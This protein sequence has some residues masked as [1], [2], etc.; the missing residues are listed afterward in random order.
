[1]PLAFVFQPTAN[2]GLSA[3]EAPFSWPT[4]GRHPHLDHITTGGQEIFGLIESARIVRQTRDGRMQE[5]EIKL[6]DWVFNAIRAH[7]VLTISR[8]YFRLRRPLERRLYELARK[9]CGN[10]KE[11]VIG[12]DL[13]QKK[14]GSSS[15]SFEFRRL[16]GNVIRED[17]AHSHMPDYSVRFSEDETKVVFRNR[18]TAPAA[19]AEIFEGLLDP[20]AYEEARAA[21]PGWDVRHLEGEWRRWCAAEEIEP[22]HPAR[23]FVRFCRCWDENRGRP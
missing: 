13:L 14:C 3:R 1:L 4:S 5:I 21:A 17:I 22:K 15:T 20:E 16:V 9:H 8:D 6:S 23:H 18:G 10:Q 2:A 19:E 11:W 12:L 7:E